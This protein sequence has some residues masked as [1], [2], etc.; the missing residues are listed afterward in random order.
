MNR[1]WVLLSSLLLLTACDPGYRLTGTV[2]DSDGKPI[3]GALARAVCARPPMP[4][5][6]SDG[7]GKF[8]HRS[9]GYFAEDCTI[10]V[11]ASGYKAQTFPL[12]PSCRK[13]SMGSCLEVEIDAVLTRASP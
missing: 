2:K 10:E 13:R 5:A 8:S 6:T 1:M 4:S 7:T 9:V 3:A 11:S 12:G